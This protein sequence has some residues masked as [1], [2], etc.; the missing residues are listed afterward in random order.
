MTD[1]EK[2]FVERRSAYR[3]EQA[4]ETGAEPTATEPTSAEPTAAEAPIEREPP[5]PAGGPIEFERSPGPDA[6]LDGAPEEAPPLPGAEIEELASVD[7]PEPS[8]YEIVQPLEIQALQF[9]GEI[10]L[11][12]DGQRSVLPRWAKH[13]IDLLGIIEDRTRGNLS[14][15]EAQYLEQVLSD[16]RTRYVRVAT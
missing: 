16:L 11:T 13:V 9:L 10:P 8:F 6:V 14:A 1:T 3:Q 5:A 2:R 4:E 12:A 15:E 7:V